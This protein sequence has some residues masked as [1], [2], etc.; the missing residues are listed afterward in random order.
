MK[1]TD[2]HL[3][4]LL[5]RNNRFIHYVAKIKGYKFYNEEAIEDTRYRATINLL[6]IYNEGREFDDEKHLYGYIVKS[7]EFAIRSAITSKEKSRNRANL[8]VYMKSDSDLDNGYNPHFDDLTSDTKEYDNTAEHID[9]L[10]KSILSEK[11]YY[12]VRERAIRESTF[13]EIAEE[14][15]MDTEATRLMYYRALKKIK[16]HDNKKTNE[17]KQR[18][19]RENVRILRETKRNKPPVKVKADEGSVIKALNFLYP[20]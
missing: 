18:I 17:N 19:I 10:M 2:K 5:P 4:E 14:L 8:K 1:L 13:K 11:A 20:K 15:E 16:N 6:R 3:K 12:A 9:S 7:F